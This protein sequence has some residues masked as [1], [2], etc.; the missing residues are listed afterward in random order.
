MKIPNGA[1]LQ[2][3]SANQQTEPFG[4]SPSDSENLRLVSLERKIPATQSEKVAEL[5][6]GAAFKLA[7]ILA[8]VPG[9]CMLAEDAARVIESRDFHVIP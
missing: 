8:D 4:L 3:F 9:V 2:L 7:A 1:L 5:E 6:P